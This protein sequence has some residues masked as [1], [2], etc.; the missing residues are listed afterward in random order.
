MDVTLSFW[1]FSFLSGIPGDQELD[2]GLCIVAVCDVLGARSFSEEVC[3]A[4]NWELLDPSKE[5]DSLVDESFFRVEFFDLDV[6][7]K[8]HG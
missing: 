7:G 8:T 3:L 5:C 4:E 1:Q 2:G 6:F